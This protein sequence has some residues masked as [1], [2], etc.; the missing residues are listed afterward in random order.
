MEN[1]QTKI[2]KISKKKYIK[3]HYLCMKNMRI[4]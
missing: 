2:S 4:G 3:Y 1:E